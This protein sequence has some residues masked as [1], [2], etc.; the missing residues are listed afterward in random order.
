MTAWAPYSSHGAATRA[1]CPFVRK[2]TNLEQNFVLS[3][4]NNCVVA[5]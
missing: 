1:V 4:T 2:S 3:R 5:P